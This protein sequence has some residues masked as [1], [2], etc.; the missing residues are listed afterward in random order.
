MTASV[1]LGQRKLPD[2]RNLVAG[3]ETSAGDPEAMICGLSGGW[4]TDVG[5][6]EAHRDGYPNFSKSLAASLAPLFLCCPPALSAGLEGH[7][8]PK[9]T[10]G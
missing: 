7:S 10:I 4:G 9:K 5:R 1:R 2:G 8:R 3:M 6:R